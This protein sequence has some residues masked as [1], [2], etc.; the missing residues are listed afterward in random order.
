M[1]PGNEEP[2]MQ[3]YVY[4]YIC[5]CVYT[6]MNVSIYIYMYI[7]VCIY[8][9]IHKRL[10]RGLYNGTRELDDAIVISVIWVPH[11]ELSRIQSR[12]RLLHAMAKRTTCCWLLSFC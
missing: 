8:A 12:G 5:I 4:I 1:A 3:I 7:H 2:A 9:Y 6:Y 11:L 10:H